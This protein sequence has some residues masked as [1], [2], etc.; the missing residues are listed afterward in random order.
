[1]ARKFY[2]PQDD[3]IIMGNAREDIDNLEKSFE[4]SAKELNRTVNS[5]R[6]RFINHLNNPYSRNYVGSVHLSIA[7][8]CS[9]ID[10][11]Y[12]IAERL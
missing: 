11:R 8:R 7:Q 3:E 2:T 1:M 10:K 4:K 5:V 12:I 6:A 9:N